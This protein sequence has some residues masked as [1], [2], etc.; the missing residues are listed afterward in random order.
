[1]AKKRAKFTLKNT[2][3][4]EGPKLPKVPETKGLE[5]PQLQNAGR[6]SARK[7]LE[8]P[9]QSRPLKRVNSNH[10]RLRNGIRLRTV[11]GELRVFLLA[12]LALGRPQ[13][14]PKLKKY[15]ELHIYNII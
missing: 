7:A 15:E 3:Q 5:H 9:R 12:S 8:N 14:P 4:K 13:T 1:M 2:S 11:K 6:G 10:K